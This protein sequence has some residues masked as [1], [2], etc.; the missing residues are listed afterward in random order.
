MCETEL[1]LQVTALPSM[2]SE[3]PKQGDKKKG[4]R[5]RLSTE[6][7]GDL[8]AD[9][10]AFASQLGLSAGGPTGGGFDDSDFR[11]EAAQKRI[12]GKNKGKQATA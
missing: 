3:Q 12:G 10:K 11:P 1:Q 6:A 4:K 8:A 2:S 7:E 5:A 9:V